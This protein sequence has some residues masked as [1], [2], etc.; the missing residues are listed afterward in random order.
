MNSYEA[1][2]ARELNKL[3]NEELERLAED[4][5]SG[6]AADFPEYKFRVGQVRMIQQIKEWIKDI[7]REMNS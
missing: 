4:L 3:L 6:G 7:E 2:V 1:A 5:V